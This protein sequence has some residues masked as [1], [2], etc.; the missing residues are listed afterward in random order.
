MGTQI[1]NPP[2][3]NLIPYTL[4][5]ATMDSLICFFSLKEGNLSQVSCYMQNKF[6][7]WKN[8]S[9]VERSSPKFDV[10]ISHQILT[11]HWDPK[12]GPWLLCPIY[13]FQITILPRMLAIPY[14]EFRSSWLSK[15]IIINDVNTKEIH[16]FKLRIESNF[17]VWS[18]VMRA[19]WVLASKARKFSLLLN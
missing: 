1:L 6:Q 5:T 19:T 18:S 7:S 17:S 11:N 9:Q 14:L 16:D 2:I 4:T 10:T 3:R 15:W 13:I 12:L 8:F